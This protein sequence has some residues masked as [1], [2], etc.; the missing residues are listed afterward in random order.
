MTLLESCPDPTRA[1]G[2]AEPLVS[3]AEHAAPDD[4]HRRASAFF[5]AWLVLAA[6]MSLAG[7]VCHALLIA[8]AHTRWLA[9][10]AA[11]VP[12]LVLLAATHSASWLVRARSSGGVFR[13]SLALTTALAAGSFALSFDAL[14]S[15]AVMLGIRDSMAWIWPAVIDIVRDRWSDRQERSSTSR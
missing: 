4:V 5:L 6:A 12:P 11:L 7:N 9:A 1:G 10:T 15:F 3:G 14:R 2:L 13:A 8:P